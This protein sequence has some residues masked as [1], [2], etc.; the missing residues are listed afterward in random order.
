MR[1]RLTAVLAI[2]TLVA[3][4]VLLIAHLASGYL[5]DS[6]PGVTH[7]NWMRD[8]QLPEYLRLSE[9]SLPG[10]HDTGAFDGWNGGDAVQCQSMDLE[11]Q[12]EAGIRVWDIRL[13]TYPM[14]LG[15]R[16]MIY[17]DVF[18]QFVWF[19]DA[20]NVADTFLGDHSTEVV[21]MR[22]KCEKCDVFGVPDFAEKVY[23]ELYRARLWAPL[24]NYNPTLAEIRG[25]IVV[26]ADFDDT[27]GVG[28]PWKAPSHSIQDDYWMDNNWS[29]E[30]KWHEDVQAWRDYANL[31]IRGDLSRLDQTYINFTSAAVGGF[32]YF[33]ASGHSSSDTGDPRQATGWLRGAWDD[34]GAPPEE[35][36]RLDRS[37]HYEFPS[38]GC[39]F[40]VCSVCFEGIN[41]LTMNY[42]NAW[43]NVHRRA[44][45]VYFNFPG[46]GAIESVINLNPVNWPPVADAGGRYV[47]NEGSPIEFSAAKSTD[48][49]GDDLDYRWDF[50][51]DGVWDT[52]WRPSPT[53][54]HTFMDD[55]TGKVVVE[56]RDGF[57]ATATATASVTVN[58]VAP[59]ATPI[60]FWQP[61]REFILPQ[62][63]SVKFSASS[64]DPGSD[65]ARYGWDFGDGAVD[66]NIYYNN[67]GSADPYPS[68][69]G[70]PMA[71]SGSVAHTYGVPGNF[72]VTLTVTDD[73]GGAA[74]QT[75]PVH[76]A[77]PAEALD[78]MEWYIQ[79]LPS[80]A[81]KAPANERKTALAKMFHSLDLMLA[82]RDYLGTIRT[83]NE[84]LRELADGSLGGKVGNDW[85]TAPFAQKE[86]RQKIDDIVA[87][88]VH[89]SKP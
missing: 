23:H 13:N 60:S 51:G 55:W 6:D 12:L 88:L 15:D 39:I 21:V 31:L 3:A 82:Q 83:L 7:P 56:V 45:I 64:N 62:V 50:N 81:F 68:P 72:T 86:L 66:I 10:T 70:N 1:C 26:L 76:V 28:I 65:D 22:I 63:H 29:L 8:K 34:I 49:D 11:H 59:T 2:A 37:D 48:R 30:R 18:A 25:K 40:G 80:A 71:A 77:G 14:G 46:S 47:A 17:H 36:N 42:L 38:E 52:G 44:G 4:S 41:T 78:I 79:T 5:H 74:T 43:G 87:Y 32:P 89:L 24:G 27:F 57:R 54:C 16:L 20:V 33:F 69:D 73:D 61:N 75:Y 53:V 67:G 9:L 84:D 58:N 19:D 85:I 35:W